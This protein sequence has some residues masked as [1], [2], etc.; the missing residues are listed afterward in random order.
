MIEVLIPRE[1]RSF[2]TAIRFKKGAQWRDDRELLQWLRG[3]KPKEF[4]EYISELFLK[5]GYKTEVTGGSYDQG[6]D[7]IAEKDGL[8]HYIQCKKF[9]GREV[10]VGPLRDFYGAIANR[11]ANGKGYFIT[12]NKFTLE[13]ER[14]AEDK[15]IELIDSFKLLKYI[16]L[17]EKSDKEEIKNC[18]KCGGKLKE[19][20]GKYGNFLGC[21]NYPKCK[22]TEN[23]EKIE[24]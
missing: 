21:S 3:M 11:L 12:T 13:A 22:Y 18:P 4:E 16:R 19:R 14:F 8:K 17:V 1:F 10:G 15:P 9:V 2:K 24:K 23:I 6:I 7:V 5:L 20:A